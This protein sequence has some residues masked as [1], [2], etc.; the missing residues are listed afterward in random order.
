MQSLFNFSSS[1]R[2]S[3][4]IGA[5]CSGK[6]FLASYAIKTLKQQRPSLTIYVIDIKA[7]PKEKH[8]YDCA[9]LLRIKNSCA[10]VNQEDVDQFI[11]W[12]QHCFSEFESLEGEKLLVL[13]EST[14]IFHFFAQNRSNKT[15]LAN[16]IVSYLSLGNALG[17]Y[18]WLIGTTISIE[19]IGISSAFRAM[20][21]LILIVHEQNSVFYQHIL[22]TNCLTKNCK[23]SVEEVMAIAH[24]SKV[25][26]AVYQDGE[27]FPMPM[28]NA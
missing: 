27:W 5:N 17:I 18:L 10:V 20:L 9:D 1:L 4:I 3:S 26:R 6:D 19:S 8:Y 16:K 21:K 22:A 15:W 28:L 11:S 14:L 7:D 2:H 13:S 12:I 25:N 24:Q 23:L